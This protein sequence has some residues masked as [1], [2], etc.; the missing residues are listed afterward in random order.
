MSTIKRLE[1]LHSVDA[2]YDVVFIHG[3]DGDPVQTW[4]YGTD[5][6]Y[7]PQW[8]ADD[9]PGARVW[10][11][12]FDAHSSKWRGDAMGLLDRSVHLL[13]VFQNKGIGHRPLLLIGH[14]LGG[15][16]AKQMLY[17]AIN[18]ATEYRDIADQV[19]SMVFL[20]TPHDGASI[21][22]LANA[23]RIYRPTDLLAD[24]LNDHPALRHL[25]N[26][27]RRWA[28]DNNVRHLVFF[29]TGRLGRQLIVPESSADP[30]VAGVTP[31]GVDANHVHICKPA[32]RDAIVYESVRNL[33]RDLIQASGG[34]APETSAPQAHAPRSSSRTGGLERYQRVF[35]GLGWS[36]T[37]RQLYPRHRLLEFGGATFPIWSQLADP[38]DRDRGLDAVLGEL[39]PG[40]DPR[41][42]VYPE[43]FDPEG[44]AEFEAKLA[45]PDPE[46][47]FNGAT[48]A[49]EQIER[50]GG[51]FTIH[52]RHGTYFHSLATSEVLER[53]LIA[54][55]DADPDRVIALDS[56]PRRRW[57]H[58]AAGGERVILDGRRRAAAL[59]VSA[60]I[61]IQ[62]SDGTYSALLAKRS[63]RVE[64]HP[65]LA[66]VAPAG[67][68]APMNAELRS[69]ATEF[70][71]RNTIL[72]EYAEEL[73]GYKD[74]E[75]GEGL[76]AKDVTA[77]PPVRELLK[78]EQAGDVVIRYCGISVPLLSL[79][80]E[81]A[82]LIFV[83]NGWLEREIARANNSD[84]WFAL[85]WEFEEVKNLDAVK[86]R[87][88][89]DLRPTNPGLVHPSV[90]VPHAAAAL[91]LSAE[92]ARDF[93]DQ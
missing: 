8:I 28:S 7:W 91:Y 25:N 35:K 4:S 5:K 69:D 88:D 13:K 79:R 3:L 34:T 84:H 9:C 72:R 50:E 17:Q 11:V 66:H 22:R 29:E 76:L 14:S 40:Q 53:E 77:L 44:R 23:L 57:L 42:P 78:A 37:L 70:S 54:H 27:Y 52:A 19:K 38:A 51:K 16:L 71:I 56:L 41:D 47:S 60:T 43:E 45:E 81:V 65:S 82:I 63:G 33:V 26:W 36:A 80:P 12:G 67:I 48:F 62:E 58:D 2:L 93:L 68:F 15:L 1:S 39:L 18:T 49:L 46:A 31:V 32:S 61:L 85:N 87:L 55:L 10:C 21:A 64:T 74:L 24:L 92:V 30:G 73:F 86:L 59:S 6:T 83:K 75:Q 90:M 20:G 89:S